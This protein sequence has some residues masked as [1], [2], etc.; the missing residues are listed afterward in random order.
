MFQFLNSSYLYS[1][2]PDLFVPAIT[3]P[4]VQC[5]EQAIVTGEIQIYEYRLTIAEQSRDYEARIA[6]SEEDEVM[7]IVRHH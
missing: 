7:A 3:R 2:T 4:L 6:L 1:A 5:V